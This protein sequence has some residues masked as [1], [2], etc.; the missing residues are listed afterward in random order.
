MGTFKPGT[1][2]FIVNGKPFDEFFCTLQ[3]R[4]RGRAALGVLALQDRADPLALRLRAG[5]AALRTGRV[6]RSFIFVAGL[7]ARVLT[8]CHLLVL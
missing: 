7:L 2:N 4:L 1:G 8:L 6:N 3:G 5:L